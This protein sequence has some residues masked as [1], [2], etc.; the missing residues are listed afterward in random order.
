M[1]HIS[2]Q[3]ICKLP[4]NKHPMI[5]R[6]TLV[7]LLALFLGV[8]SSQAQGFDLSLGAGII[9]SDEDDWGGLLLWPR[10]GINEHIYFGLYTGVFA[11]NEKES[12]GTNGEIN[13]DVSI[14]P[15][16]ATATYQFGSGKFHP[17]IGLSVGTYLYNGTYTLTAPGTSLVVDEN[18]SYGAFGIHAGINY[19][20]SE[21]LFIHLR[22]GLDSVSDGEEAFVGDDEEQ[23]ND[24]VVPF[25][26][27]IGYR[28]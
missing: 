12:F 17:Y 22:T 15:V 27:G 16:M 2:P 10:Y 28:F 4:L 23:E 3:L 8:Q 5:V 14:V 18:E 21:K 11:E 24:V 13:V 19:Q 6:R 7:V 1:I 25:L 20:V 9:L 26:V